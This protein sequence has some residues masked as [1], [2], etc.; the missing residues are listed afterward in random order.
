[1]MAAARAS[2]TPNYH[3]CHHVK[4]HQI[5]SRSSHIRVDHL[6]RKPFREIASQVISKQ[7][8]VTRSA[9]TTPPLP[10][11]IGAENIESRL[12]LLQQKGHL[13]VFTHADRE[14]SYEATK[15]RHDEDKQL[16]LMLMNEIKALRL[17]VADLQKE[18]GEIKQRLQIMK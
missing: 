12:R 3:G 11:E 8:P 4:M 5:P 9:P 1:M 7:S 15:S 6:S 13:A 14:H 10:G 18:L 16:T 2:R 17:G